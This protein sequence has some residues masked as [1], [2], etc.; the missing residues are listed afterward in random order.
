MFPYN[1]CSSPLFN[2]SGDTFYGI[3][4]MFSYVT[5]S[6][7]YAC[8]YW[9]DIVFTLS[10]SGCIRRNFPISNIF[11]DGFPYDTFS[12]PRFVLTSDGIMMISKKNNV[13]SASV[14]S[15]PHGLGGGPSPWSRAQIDDCAKFLVTNVFNSLHDITWYD[16][17]H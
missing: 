17:K 13:H 9:Y 14:F 10:H 3:Y 15:K 4:G 5:Y 6:Y 11:V 2:I 12:S 8:T 7:Y 1:I 16:K